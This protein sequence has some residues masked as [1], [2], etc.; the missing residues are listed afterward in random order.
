MRYLAIHF[1]KRKA[2]AG[3][4]ISSQMSRPYLPVTTYTKKV[5]NRKVLH[6]KPG[7]IGI[8]LMFATIKIATTTNSAIKL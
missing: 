7:H 5:C 4:Q 1:C 2:G 6:S 3:V 8:V